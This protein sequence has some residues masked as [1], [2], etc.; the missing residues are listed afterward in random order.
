MWARASRA[1]KPHP[2]L[3][4]QGHAAPP[5]VPANRLC[6]QRHRNPRAFSN[7]RSSN[8]PARSTRAARRP[9]RTTPASPPLAPTR[10][11]NHCSHKHKCCAPPPPSIMCARTLRRQPRSNAHDAANRSPPAPPSPWPT[12]LSAW[13]PLF[14]WRIKERS[15]EKKKP[16]RKKGISHARTISPIKKRVHQ[17]VRPIAPFRKK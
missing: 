17:M 11:P 14:T 5:T 15:L 2:T 8:G 1:N 3:L 9:V 7:A 16:H 10:G 4:S 6:A 13:T 12:T